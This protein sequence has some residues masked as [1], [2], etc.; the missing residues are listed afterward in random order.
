MQA[1]EWASEWANVGVCVR[2]VRSEW[3]DSVIFNRIYVR[4][5]DLIRSGINNSIGCRYSPILFGMYESIAPHNGETD[6]E[7]GKNVCQKDRMKSPS[8]NSTTF[9]GFG[10]FIEVVAS[11]CVKVCGKFNQPLQ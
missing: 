5:I 8:A 3:P 2:I 6:N 9:S 4:Y 11:L 1:A 10:L 7:R